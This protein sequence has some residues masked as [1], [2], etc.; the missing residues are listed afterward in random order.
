MLNLAHNGRLHWPL[1]D[2]ELGVGAV[3][4]VGEGAGAGEAMLPA[5]RAA[6]HNFELLSQQSG[7]PHCERVCTTHNALCN[8]AQSLS[9]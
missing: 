6:G 9:N 3:A 7:K 2:S 8:T 4:G 5:V 1:P